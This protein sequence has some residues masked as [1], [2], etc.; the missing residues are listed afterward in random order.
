MNA[1]L[2]GHLWRSQRTKLVIV[3]FAILAWSAFMPVIYQSFGKQM[4]ALVDSG[5]IPKQLTNFGGGDVFSLEG[6][7]A[8]G[9]I[10]PI[11]IILVSI[12]AIGFA[13]SA[14][15]GE[16]QRGTLEVLLARPL[17]RRTIYGTL[18]VA[19]LLFIAIVLLAASLGTVIGSALVGVMDQLPLARLPLL[20]LNGVLLWGAFAAIALAASV[21]F[22]RLTP[23]IGITLAI[24][25]VSYFLYVLGSLWPDAKGLEPY[26]LF[27]Y[28]TS[29]DILTGTVDLVAF[30]LLALVGAIA[31]GV[32]LIVFPRRDLAAPS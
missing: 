29:R 7:V 19:A 16:R 1:V 28:L 20:W 10:H 32:A 6:A 30:A 13:T 2:F 17:S 24:V 21:S 11:A 12:F 22:D 9:Y 25:V 5:V 4:Q 3:S 8:L 23:A 27:H 18:L 26:S 14:V 15:A 31:I